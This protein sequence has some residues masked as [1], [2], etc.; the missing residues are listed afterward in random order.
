MK[1]LRRLDEPTPGLADYRAVEREHPSWDGLRSH[2]GGC[3]YRELRHALVENQR[4]LCGYCETS[5]SD[6]DIQVEHVLPRSAGAPGREGELAVGNL[7]ACCSG[8]EKRRREETADGPPARSGHTCG[9]AK[10]NRVDP[11]FLDPRDLPATP[12]VFKVDAEGQITPNER[13]CVKAGIPAARVTATIAMLRLNEERLRQD[14]MD[15]WFALLSVWSGYAKDAARLRRAARRA[16]LPDATG[17]LREFFTTAR[18]YFGGAAETVLAEAP[19]E[20]V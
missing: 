8:Q 3:A 6:T 14:R 7:I 5:L 12:P 15:R 17:R 1:S 10:G 18:S 19:E 4:G 16:L 2:R 20:W 13:G 9:Q 11:D